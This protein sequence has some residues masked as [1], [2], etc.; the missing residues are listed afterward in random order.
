LRLFLGFAFATLVLRRTVVLRRT[1]FL[2]IGFAAGRLARRTPD[3]VAEAARTTAGLRF[4]RLRVLALV[5]EAA[6][7]LAGLGFVVR[8]RVLMAL[9]LAAET[10]RP[11]YM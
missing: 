9:A 10:N 1:T 6:R 4:R 3:L 2:R 7:T 8:R 11:P 5:A